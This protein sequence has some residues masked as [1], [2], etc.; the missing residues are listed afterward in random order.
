MI[1]TNAQHLGSQLLQ[2]VVIL[3]KRGSLRRS[4]GGEIEH[5]EGEDD[6]LLASELAEADGF[7]ISRG[8]RKVGGHFSDFCGHH[9]SFLDLRADMSCSHL[10]VKKEAG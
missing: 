2:A 8:K 7:I 1:A 3:P 9:Q 6:V 10:G 5:M 4:A